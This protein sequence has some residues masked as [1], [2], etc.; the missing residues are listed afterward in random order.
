MNILVFAPHNDD[1]TIGVGGT[2]VKLINAG[3][4]VI[5]MEV[6]NEDRY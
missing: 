3:H 2:I 6:G 1:E 5:D 4:R